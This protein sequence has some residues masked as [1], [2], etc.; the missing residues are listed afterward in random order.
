MRPTQF[1]AD[2]VVALLRQ[3]T[4]AALP[5][6]MAA[7]GTRV[8]RRTAFRKLKDLHA[9]T[10]YSHRGGYY[11]LDELADFDEHGLWA[12]VGVRRRP[13]LP[14]RHPR[15][16]RRGVRQR[17]GSRTLRR[18]AGQPARCRHPGRPAQARR[19][20]AADAAQARRPVPLLRDRPRAGDP[21]ELV[22]TFRNPGAKWDR[23]PELVNDHDFRSDADGRA[24]PYGIY[25]PRA[26]AG[27]VFVGRTADTPA[28]AVDCIEKWW[29]T[30]G[31]KRYPEAKTLQIL[32]DGGGSNSC[33]ARAWKF[34][35][36]HRF[37]NRHGLPVRV[38]H[39]PPATSKWNPIEH[40][41]FCEISK[42]WA[43]R[44]LDSFETI[45]KYLRTTRTSTGLRVRAHLVRKTY[46][47]GVKVT[48][49]QMRELRITPNSVLPKWNYTIE[50]M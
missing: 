49:A 10:S 42:N 36:Q 23:S 3:Q 7:L 18:R 37:C 1:S 24:V 6:V 32:A 22:G 48:D 28:F 13:L 27:T 26:N 31:R 15:R 9:R 41:L 29:R 17:R 34:N 21:S 47:T 5:D 14:R 25:D 39:Y 30:E 45:L 16:N 2:T 38:A 46:E 20:R 4:V 33:T 12:F 19:R 40:R 8:S 11:T 44:P 35:L 43:G 50:P